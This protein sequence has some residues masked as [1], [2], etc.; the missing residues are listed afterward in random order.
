[1][2]L[3]YSVCYAVRDSVIASVYSAVK[4]SVR[5][6]VRDAVYWSSNTGVCVLVSDSTARYSI[7]ALIR[8]ISKSYDT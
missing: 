1:M 2:T 7:H 6:S 3:S 4:R 8:E 5:H